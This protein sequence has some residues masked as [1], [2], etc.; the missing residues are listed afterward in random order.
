MPRIPK[1]LITN[2]DG[3]HG[4]GLAPLVRAMRRLGRVMVVVPDAERSADSHSLTLHKPLRVRMISPGF[5]TLNG[6]PA[7]CARLGILELMKSGVDL[8]VS[9]INHGLNLGDDVVYSGTVAGAMEGALLHVPSLAFSQTRRGKSSRP[10]DFRAGASL[11]LKI[12]RLVLRHGLES[13]VCLNVNFPTPRR[14][15]FRGVLPTR[16]GRRL[17]TKVVT[18]R[19][20]PRGDSYYW[21]AGRSVGGVSAAATDIRALDRGYVSVTPLHIDNTD[22]PTLETL[23]RWDL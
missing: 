21:L 5:H 7:D 19:L 18:K 13:G 11:A 6:S 15:G 20:D 17:Y 8:V 1:I 12:V 3:P 16:L 14:G 9:G 23:A 4:P 10:P 2:D 22:L